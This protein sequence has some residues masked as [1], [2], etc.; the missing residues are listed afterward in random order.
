MG[1]HG[2]P[3]LLASASALVICLVGLGPSAEGRWN[4]HNE[5][6]ATQVMLAPGAPEPEFGVVDGQ[7]CRG[8]L[9]GESASFRNSSNLNDPLT[10]FDTDPRRYGLWTAP[11]G[12]TQFDQGDPSVIASNAAG[13]EV[14]ATL[15]VAF[16]TPPRRPVP[17]TFDT[18]TSSPGSIVVTVARFSVELPSSVHGGDPL[19]LAPDSG[20]AT[21]IDLTAVACPSTVNAHVDVRP[22]SSANRVFL[23]QPESLIQMRVFGSAKVDVTQID[24]VRLEYALPVG[25]D[26]ARDVNHDGYLDRDYSFRTASI[27]V[28]CG[29]KN[30]TVTGGRPGAPGFKGTSPITTVGCS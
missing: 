7:V 14:A 11:P 1:T 29:Q 15:V 10:S 16:D 4:I 28:V 6:D 21:F 23:K 30:A 25:Q 18:D 24:R 13:T 12:F 20:D 3:R 5:G 19:G 22:S 26:A 9:V 2:L 8:R 27:G 17:K